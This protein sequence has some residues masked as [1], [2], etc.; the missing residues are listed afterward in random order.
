MSFQDLENSVSN[1]SS[2]TDNAVTTES[3]QIVFMVPMSNDQTSY[4]SQIPQLSESNLNTTLVLQ[5][6]SSSASLL[7]SRSSAGQST[8]FIVDTSESC[9]ILPGDT[10]NN[11]MSLK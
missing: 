1:V 2:N 5:P 3:S 4:P 11:Q 9:A 10:D 7:S 6:E 8:S